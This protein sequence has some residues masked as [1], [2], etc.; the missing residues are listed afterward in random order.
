MYHITYKNVLRSNK[1]RSDY[2]QWLHTFWPVQQRWG[3]KSFELWD[4]NGGNQHLVFCRY[5]VDDIDKWN[6]SALSPEAEPLIKALDKIVDTNQL[7]IKIKL[8]RSENA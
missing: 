4:S 7:S 8:L 3:A 2:E 6:E 5:A 1:E